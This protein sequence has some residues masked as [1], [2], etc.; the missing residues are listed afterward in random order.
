[1]SSGG[2]LKSTMGMRVSALAGTSIGAI[3]GSG[4]AAG[5]SADELR[6]VLD[7]VLTLAPT[8]ERLRSPKRL[9]GWLD[10]LGLEF[11]KSHILEADT[12]IAEMSTYVDV[13][14]F[15]ELRTP[16]KIVAAEFWSRN[17]VVFDS[18]PLMPAMAA[19]FCLPG[20]FR[21]GVPSDQHD[22]RKIRERGYGTYHAPACVPNRRA[23]LGLLQSERNLRF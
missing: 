17:E 2:T 6:A 21:P 3:I 1:M 19:S 10:L 4:Y 9:F 18:G 15:E 23:A 14:T 11:G 8:L 7:E 5:K 22:L 20:I 16:L 12:F 13:E